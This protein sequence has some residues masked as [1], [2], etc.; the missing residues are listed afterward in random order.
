MKECIESYMASRYGLEVSVK[1]P[2]QMSIDPKY[3]TGD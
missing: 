1:E 3:K 2:A